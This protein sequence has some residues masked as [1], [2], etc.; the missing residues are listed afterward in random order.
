MFTKTMLGKP[1]E[2]QSMNEHSLGALRE[3]LP[4]TRLAKYKNVLNSRE[5]SVME[6]FDLS[7]E[8]FSYGQF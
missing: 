2:K 5:T 6:N 7:F 3:S 4:N 8:M 1:K